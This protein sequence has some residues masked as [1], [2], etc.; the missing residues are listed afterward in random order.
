MEFDEPEMESP[1]VEMS[2][3]MEN[4]LI[5]KCPEPSFTEMYQKKHLQIIDT[6]TEMFDMDISRGYVY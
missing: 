5:W 3:D 1:T 2:I 4:N 6:L